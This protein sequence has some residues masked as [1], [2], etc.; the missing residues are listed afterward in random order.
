[1]GRK[2]TA[3]WP[4]AAGR[5]KSGPRAPRRRAPALPALEALVAAYPGP[6]ARL[7]RNLHVI[8]ANPSAQPL[9]IDL[10]AEDSRLAHLVAQVA[11]GGAGR[12]EAIVL[13]TAPVAT[14][15]EVAAIPVRDE[16]VLLGRDTSFNANLR[17]ALTDSRRRYKDLVEISSDFVWETDTNGR[18]AFVSPGGALGWRAEELNG[19]AASEFM[20][21]DEADANASPF[22]GRRRLDNV[23]VWL[24]R[25]DGQAAC[26]SLS[27]VPLHDPD[28]AWLGAR[29]VC[30]D[31]TEAS[32]RDT[33]LAEARTR[34]QLFTYIVR[35]IRDEVE[36][37]AMLSAAASAAARAT[38]AAGTIIWRYTASGGFVTVSEFGAKLPDDLAPARV[39]L[40]RLAT[41]DAV[42][43]TETPPVEIGAGSGQLIGAVTRFRQKVNGAIALWRRNGAAGWSAADRGLLSELADQL[44]IAQAQIANIEALTALARTDPLTGLL[45]RRTFLEY[46][47]P[48]VARVHRSGQPGALVYLDLD[49]FKLVND[50]FGHGRGDEAL[51]HLAQALLKESRMTDLVARLGGDEFVVWLDDTDRGGAT[52]KAKRLLALDKVLAPF[53]GDPAR[54]LSVSIGVVMCEAGGASS[55]EELIASADTAMYRA[56]KSGKNGIVFAEAGGGGGAA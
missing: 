12:L 22:S 28:G 4:R 16:I 47:A 50:R 18:F 39:L 38:S 14:T 52:D 6:A 53:S 35:T 33:A 37:A 54:K 3:Q 31:V 15:M 40:P 30:R 46:V 24:R 34:E 42:L 7:D 51:K 41:D 10:L 29:G 11:E 25:A 26:V 36:P 23:S 2:S 27:S 9:L 13:P 5:A 17:D 32:L 21:E 56:K 44:G 55:A 19:R 49:N 48:R 43:A 1:M 20:I 8:A 45:N